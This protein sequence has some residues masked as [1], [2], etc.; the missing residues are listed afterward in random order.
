MQQA[1][2]SLHAL[3][4][5]GGPWVELAC[6]V[7]GVVSVALSPC[8][9]GSIPLIV[10]YVGGQETMGS[11]RRAGLYALVFTCGLF[12]T[13]TLIGSASALLGNLNADLGPWWTLAVAALLIWVGLDLLGWIRVPWSG[14]ALA[15]LKVR[16][17][18]GALLL[19]LAY[20]LLSGSCTLGFIAPVLGLASLQESPP[21]GLLL[22]ALF[23]LGHCLPIVLA[24]SSTALVQRILDSRGHRT[25]S[26]W[27]HRGAGLLV[28]SLGLILA[29]SP[30]LGES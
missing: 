3:L 17:L 11:P 23:G 22:V 28:L 6:F 5:G 1:L 21:M 30:F 2:I 25:S 16:G 29:A 15:R 18:L 14:S 26:A 10:G 24:G 20:G 9:L 7:W 13:I 12:L 4:V 19:G 8:H 27:F